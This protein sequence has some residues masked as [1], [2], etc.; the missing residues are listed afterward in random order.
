MVPRQLRSSQLL[1][2][3]VASTL[4]IRWVKSLHWRRQK[5]E[6][7]T[8]DGQPLVPAFREGSYVAT[9]SISGTIVNIPQLQAAYNAAKAAVIHLCKN[10]P[11]FLNFLVVSNLTL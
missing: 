2:M 3:F 1:H 5:K 6:Q 7:T 9:A 4:L 10:F 11:C 8:I